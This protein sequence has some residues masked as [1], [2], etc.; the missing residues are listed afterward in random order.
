MTGRNTTLVINEELHQQLHHHLYPGDGLEA[1][2]LLLVTRMAGRRLKLLA[3]EVIP[4]PLEACARRTSDSI[5]WPGE[6]VEQAI[7]RAEEQGRLIVAIHSH[8]GGLFDFSS[9]DDASDQVLMPALFHGTGQQCGSAVMTPTGAVKARLYDEHYAPVPI[10]LV[11]RA[12]TTI[13]LWWN[14][15]SD[16]RRTIRPLPFTSGMTGHL[17]RLSACVIGVSGTGSIMA[18]Q[19]ARLGFGEVILIDF[20]KI[21]L[22]NLNRILNS[23]IEDAAINELKV[24]V[25]KRAIEGYRSDCDVVAVDSNIST[26]AAVL[27]ACDA[28][29]LFCCVDSAEGRHIADRLSAYFLMPLFD[30]GV[31]I[32]TRTL[33]TK[34]VVI[35]EVCGRIDYVRPGGPTLRDRGVYSPALLEAEYLA[36]VAPETYR[37][38][39]ASGYLPGLSEEAPAVIS[40][41]MRAASACMMEFIARTFPFRHVNGRLRARTIF[42]LTDGDEDHYGEDDFHVSGGL[43]LGA[44]TEEPLLGL[45][46]LSARTQ[47]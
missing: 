33:P 43:V 21:E 46:A 13:D 28:D 15:D 2:A 29:V 41:N 47:P 36:R 1:A 25:F 7:S 42:T 34:E 14:S 24:K 26:R 35:T 18:E 19:A 37:A 45:P 17:K 22:R 8:P 32:P 31:S 16:E 39:V 3:R 10:D 30:V 40:L 38:R 11:M 5:T 6:F 9:A 44:G 23:T 20:D 4:V 12:G 27:A